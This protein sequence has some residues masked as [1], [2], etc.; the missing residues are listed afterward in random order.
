MLFFFFMP[1][2]GGRGVAGVLR[3]VCQPLTEPTAAVDGLGALC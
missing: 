1:L 2:V 3:G